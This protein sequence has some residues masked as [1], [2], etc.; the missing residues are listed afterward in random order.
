MTST[1]YRQSTHRP[2]EGEAAK[3]VGADPENELLWR[4]N[5]RR[6]EAEAVRDAVLAVSG[7]LDRTM[8]GAPI[9]VQSNPDGLV[10]VSEKGL[11]PTSKW[12]SSLYVR[13]LRGSHPT[14]VGFRLSMFEIFDF[15]EVVINCTRRANSTTPLQSLAL[16][17]SGF[18]LEQARH[19]AERVRG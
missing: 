15:P 6:L 4:M 7:K 17:N 16:I 18:M 19:F 9:P 10:V 5:L 11:T 13:S 3:A 12:R 1:A 2:T 8:G 14:G